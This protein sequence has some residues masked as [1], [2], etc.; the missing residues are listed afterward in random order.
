MAA[1][2]QLAKIGNNLNQLTRHLNQ[3]ASWPDA[4]MVW[5]LLRHIE[6]SIADVD[7]AVAQVTNGRRAHDPEDHPGQGRPR[8]TAPHRLPLRTGPRQRALGPAP[9][10][11]LERLRPRHPVHL[12]CQQSVSGEAADGRPS[13]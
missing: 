3:D 4:E 1:N 7:M 9:S 2:G 11:V 13:A 6:A 10:G 5:R 12:S 8:H